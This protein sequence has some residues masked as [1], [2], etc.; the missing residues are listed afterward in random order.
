MLD[1]EIKF[2]EIVKNYNIKEFRE[3]IKSLKKLTGIEGKE[4]SFL[5]MDT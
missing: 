5:F 1:Y 3:F 2:I 4:C